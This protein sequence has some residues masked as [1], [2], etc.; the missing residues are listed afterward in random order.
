MSSAF[1][2]GGAMDSSGHARATYPKRFAGGAIVA[3]WCPYGCADTVTKALHC[4]NPGIR[5]G[6]PP[7]GAG[8]RVPDVRPEPTGGVRAGLDLG[9]ATPTTR[10]VPRNRQELVEQ[11]TAVHGISATPARSRA[12]ADA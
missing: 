9:R 3:G 1:Q 7:I 12:Q 5:P 10:V 6:A 2:P 4:I 8:R 11:W